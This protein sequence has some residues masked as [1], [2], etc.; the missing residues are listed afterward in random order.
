MRAE[1][2]G[3]NAME[4]IENLALAAGLQGNLISR[5]TTRILLS[6]ATAAHLFTEGRS[7]NRRSITG[8]CQSPHVRR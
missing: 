6:G 2:V 7:R 4:S 8:G 1:I 5:A 3:I